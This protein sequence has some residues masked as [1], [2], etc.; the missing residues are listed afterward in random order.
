MLA[1]VGQRLNL[2]RGLEKRGQVVAQYTS[3]N[4]RQVSNWYIKGSTED[5]D[6]DYGNGQQ[7]PVTASSLDGRWWSWVG[8][9]I[10]IQ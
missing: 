6:H 3:Q 10:G 9:W 5:T 7:D 1:D 4:L 8:I 2:G